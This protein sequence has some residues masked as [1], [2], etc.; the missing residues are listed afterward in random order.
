MFQQ[1]Q[2]HYYAELCTYMNLRL[3]EIMTS[4]PV[5]PTARVAKTLPHLYTHR[6]VDEAAAAQQPPKAMTDVIPRVGVEQLLGALKVLASANGGR[7]AFEDVRQLLQRTSIKRTAGSREAM[8][9]STRDALAELQRLGFATTGPLPRRRSEVERLRQSP[10]A[11]TDTGAAMATLFSEKPSRAYDALLVTW[12]NNHPYFREFVVRLTTG[13]LYVPD[14]TSVKQVG[15]FDGRPMTE[16]A[17]RIADDGTARLARAGVPEDVRLKYEASVHERLSKLKLPDRDSLRTDSKQWVD[18]IEDA[19]VL[20]ALLAAESLPF[21][22]VTFQHLVRISQQF[23]CASWTSSHP[24]FTGRIVYLTSEFTPS[25]SGSE[26]IQSVAHH[27]RA[28]ASERFESRV[29]E[30]YAALSEGRTAPYVDAYALRAF[31]CVE[32]GIQPKVF[33]LC[34]QDFA[35]PGHSS[36]VIVY[37]ELPMRPPPQGELYVELAGQRIGL[38]KLIV[39]NGEGKKHG[40]PLLS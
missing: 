11:I 18:L 34:F 36:G 17:R 15:D 1:A 28:W 32:L 39:Q 2:E 33:E 27:G 21:D 29:I 13:P 3:S 37:T 19:A 14:V 23:L 6:V 5:V 30:A 24:R 9:T 31:V 20:P 26:P 10:C 4:A 22:H 16:V 8:W 12:V 38:I 40:D 35:R 25:L 7:A